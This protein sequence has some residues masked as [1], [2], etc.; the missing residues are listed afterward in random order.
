MTGAATGAALRRFVFDDE[1]TIVTAAEHR[2][3]LLAFLRDGTGVRVD[4]SGITDLDT[5]GLQVLLLARDEGVRRHLP[6][7]FVEPS[8]AVAD[9]LAMTR[10]EL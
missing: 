6:V 3:R 8:P 9:V 1:L 4:L 2:D 10:L 5:A 7:E